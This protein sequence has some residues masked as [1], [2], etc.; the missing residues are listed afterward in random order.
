M[1]L[2][3]LS[4]AQIKKSLPYIQLEEKVKFYVE[5]VANTQQ[6]VDQLAESL[7]QES[8]AHK[9]A[10]EK[11]REGC[12]HEKSFLEK[13]IEQLKQNLASL[14]KEEEEEVVADELRSA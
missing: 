10:L 1:K 7:E 5:E 11:V 12:G 9:A 6:L 2:D 3:S 14:R 13:E 4:E 8:G